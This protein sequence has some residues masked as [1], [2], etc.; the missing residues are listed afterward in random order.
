MIRSFFTHSPAYLLFSLP[1]LTF[2]Y[3]FRGSWLHKR[4]ALHLISFFFSA[5]IILQCFFLS[6]V[7]RVISIKKRCEIKVANK[8]NSWNFIFY[9]IFNTFWRAIL[10]PRVNFWGR[11]VL[12][13]VCFFVFCTLMFYKHTAIQ[14]SHSQN[15]MSNYARGPCLLNQK[16]PILLRAASKM[17]AQALK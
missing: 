7:S 13:N 6:V 1:A 3:D 10:V 14:P 11:C 9:W 12:N 15:F 5:T 2:F 4:W 17:C 8:K 16:I